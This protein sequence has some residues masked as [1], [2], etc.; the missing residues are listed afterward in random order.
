MSAVP[1]PRRGNRPLPAVY[2][3]QAVSGGPVKIGSA[4]EPEKRLGSL[5]TGNPEA[6]RIIGLM[7]D[8][9]ERFFHEKF[10]HLRL[11]G[12]WFR[13]DPELLYFISRWNDA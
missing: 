12:E 10:A 3:I 6:L 1:L 4:W 11:R 13:P 9:P 2:F 8:Q 7:Y 5:Q